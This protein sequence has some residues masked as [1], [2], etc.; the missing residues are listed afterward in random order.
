MKL[1]DLNL[2]SGLEGQLALN[3]GIVVAFLYKGIWVFPLFELFSQYNLKFLSELTNDRTPNNK[4]GETLF[5]P[6]SSSQKGIISLNG[7]L[8]FYIRTMSDP[9][10]KIDLN[11]TEDDDLTEFENDKLFLDTIL[12]HIDSLNIKK[13]E[14]KIQKDDDAH[15]KQFYNAVIADPSCLTNDSTIILSTP[16]LDRLQYYLNNPKILKLL[17]KIISPTKITLSQMQNL[18]VHANRQ[19]TKTIKTRTF[20]LQPF[21]VLEGITQRYRLYAPQFLLAN[22]KSYIVQICKD[23]NTAHRVCEYYKEHKI[24]LGFY[25]DGESS[26][27][28]SPVYNKAAKLIRDNVSVGIVKASSQ[29]V[30]MLKL[31]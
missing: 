8:H 9:K 17:L 13:L 10:L 24:N 28:T 3:N 22:D 1:D 7:N 16:I 5:P 14:I 20:M 12:V 31:K 26:I 19:T 18:H 4:I 23:V 21:I 29:I 15:F 6:F 27:T 30:A 2:S 11:F 25:G